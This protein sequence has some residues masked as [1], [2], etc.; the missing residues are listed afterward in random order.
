MTDKPK[1]AFYW[2]AACGGCDEAV[3]DL[4]EKVLDVVAAVDIVFWPV[5]LDF[6]RRDVEAMADGSLA[7]AFVN[8]A[9]RSTE[10]EEM[11]HLLRRKAR[12]LIAFGSCSQLGGVPGLANLSDRESVLATTY[13]ENPSTVNP[14][15]V[16]PQTRH[17][18]DGYHLTL[19]GLYDTV[20][21][22]D[23][24]TDVDY[25]LPTS[26][27]WRRTSPCATSV[28]ARNPSRRSWS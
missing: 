20:R 24:V 14:N 9:V 21:A 26:P 19:P 5:A 11:V 17:N 25:Y 3:V 12:A 22:L 15:G 7:A 13:R 27:C 18:E 6:K 1:V 8:G 16:V 23:Q 2:C 4:A 10:Q 28:R